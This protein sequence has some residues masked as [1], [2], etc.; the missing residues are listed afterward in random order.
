M[1]PSSKRFGLDVPRTLGFP[2]YDCVNWKGGGISYKPAAEEPAVTTQKSAEDSGSCGEQGIDGR[3]LRKSE[4]LIFGW[5]RGRGGE[6]M[7]LTPR[8]QFERHS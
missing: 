4:L 8:L 7:R 3:I 5:D 1:S 2:E 6:A